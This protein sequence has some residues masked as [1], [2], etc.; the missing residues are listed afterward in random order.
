MSNF[1]LFIMDISIKSTLRKMIYEFSFENLCV[2][3]IDYKTDNKHNLCVF[4][5]SLDNPTKLIFSDI[6]FFESPVFHFTPVKLF[7]NQVVKKY[8]KSILDE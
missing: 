4:V 7:V 2:T 8:F 6:K 1:N 3:A 5:T